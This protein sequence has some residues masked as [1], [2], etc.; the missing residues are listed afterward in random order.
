MPLDP[1]AAALIKQMA[2]A[3]GPKLEELPPDD[4]RR[5]TSATFKMLAGAAEEV[6]KVEDRK[7]PGPAGQIRFGFIRQQAPDLFRCWCSTTAADG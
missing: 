6:A 7:I 5:L 3:P 2:V 4:A 1:Q